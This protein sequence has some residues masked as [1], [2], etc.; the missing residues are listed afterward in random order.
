[1]HLLMCLFHRNVLNSYH[2]AGA[3]LDTSIQSGTKTHFLSSWNLSPGEENKEGSHR[4]PVGL[5]VCIHTRASQVALGVKNLTAPAGDRSR[6]GPWLRKVPEGGR[7][8]PLQY[9]CLEYPMDRGAWW[10]TV[11]RGHKES[12]MTEHITTFRNLAMKI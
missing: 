9:F 12:D 8:S 3:V 1:M 11:H 7:S 6:F 4:L 2:M 5:H 10:A